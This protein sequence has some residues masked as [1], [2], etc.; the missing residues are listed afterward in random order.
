MGRKI[1]ANSQLQFCNVDRG[2][3]LYPWFHRYI[4]ELKE[5]KQRW[6]KSGR[7]SLTQLESADNSIP[8]LIEWV[9]KEKGDTTKIKQFITKAGHGGEK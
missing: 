7:K 3:Y 5:E 9:M 2:S 1:E 4:S 8:K 6:T